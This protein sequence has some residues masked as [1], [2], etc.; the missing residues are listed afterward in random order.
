MTSILCVGY[1]TRTMTPLSHRSREC[2]CAPSS[3]A[4]V[5]CVACPHRVKHSVD[6]VGDNNHV[7][8]FA[9]TDVGM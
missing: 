3:S 6:E 4:S 9:E 8:I 7:K 1:K 2:E 5:R